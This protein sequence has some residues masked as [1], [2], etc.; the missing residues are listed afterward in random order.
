M[1][2]MSIQLYCNPVRFIITVMPLMVINLLSASVLKFI[3]EITIV[4]E[5]LSILNQLLECSLNNDAHKHYDID[6]KVIMEC[7]SCI[8]QNITLAKTMVASLVGIHK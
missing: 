3:T 8:V 6:I 7:F 1:F 5:K 2:I 4:V